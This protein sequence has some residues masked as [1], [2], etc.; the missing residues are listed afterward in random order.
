M[1]YSN[2][3]YKIDLDLKIQ[4][5]NLMNQNMN[6][7]QI[8]W[9]RTLVPSLGCNANSTFQFSNTGMKIVSEKKLGV[10]KGFVSM[11]SSKIGFYSDLRKVYFAIFPLMRKADG[12]FYISNILKIYFMRYIT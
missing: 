2:L 1:S 4:L 10:A 3:T 12:K 8:S 6:Q 9:S 7:V 5:N 11:F